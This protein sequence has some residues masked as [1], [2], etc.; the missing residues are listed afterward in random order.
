M[1]NRPQISKFSPA[2]HL[3]RH[4]ELIKSPPPLV[5]RPLETRGGGLFVKGGGVFWG[6][7]GG[8]LFINPGPLKIFWR[9]RRQS[10]ILMV[11]VNSDHFRVLLHVH[12]RRRRKFWGFETLKKRFLMG[13]Q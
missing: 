1:K 9:L 3:T 4:L 11:S 2:A 13:N 6:G 10:Q 7:G 8:G 5:G 12:R